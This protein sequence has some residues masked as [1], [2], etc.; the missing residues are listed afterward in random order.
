MFAI[1][2]VRHYKQ[3]EEQ[4][5]SLDYHEYE[6]ESFSHNILSNDTIALLYDP[7]PLVQ[8]KGMIKEVTSKHGRNAKERALWTIF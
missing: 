2:P 8:I 1:H 7:V 6:P 4:E 5:S 3:T